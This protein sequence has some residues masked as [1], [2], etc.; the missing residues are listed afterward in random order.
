MATQQITTRLREATKDLHT[1]AEQ[2][3]VQKRFVQGELSREGYAAWLGQMLKMHQA[4]EPELDR[5]AGSATAFAGV[6]ARYRPKAPLLIE[7]LAALGVDASAV[8]PTRAAIRFANDVQRLADET[9]IALLGVVY[10]FEGATNGGKYLVRAA[11]ATYRFPDNRGT[12]YLDPYGDA[13]AACWAAFGE[14]MDEA[15]FTVDQ[16]QR[17]V[18]VACETFRGIIG[19]LDD[20]VEC[21]GARDDLEDVAVSV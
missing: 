18:D 1:E 5:L 13:Q 10:V 7:D 15:G 4:F 14:G 21:T 6:L 20:L 2:H 8:Q 19:V 9:P 12:R 17:I 11:S 16:A 3:P